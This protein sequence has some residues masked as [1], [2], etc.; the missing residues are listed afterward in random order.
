MFNRSIHQMV[1]ITLISLPMLLSS[2]FHTAIEAQEEEEVQE[3]DS[4]EFT[5]INGTDRAITEFYVS[6]PSEDN[7]GENILDFTLEPG[8]EAIVTIND[9]LPDCTYDLMANF[10]PGEGVGEGKVYQTGVS[11]CEGTEYT[12]SN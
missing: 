1:G 9:G 3:Y 7:W 2:G 4:V 12:Y 5:L 10:G 11:I 6:H 8:D